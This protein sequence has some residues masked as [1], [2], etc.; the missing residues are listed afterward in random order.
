MGARGAGRH[1]DRLPG[2]DLVSTRSGLASVNHGWSMKGRR[3]GSN[4][5]MQE[6][7][8]RN[9]SPSAARG[10]DAV[11]GST[12]YGS[13]RRTCGSPVGETGGPVEAAYH[14]SHVTGIPAGLESLLAGQRPP[15]AVSA[16]GYAGY[17]AVGCAGRM[18]TPPRHRAPGTGASGLVDAEVSGPRGRRLGRGGRRDADPHRPSGSSTGPVDARDRVRAV[19]DGRLTLERIKDVMARRSRGRTP[20]PSGA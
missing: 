5:M 9:G 14:L 17:L 19:G 11:T 15:S 20:P 13:V 2:P 10:V 6:V 16:I 12:A 18:Q 8:G 7:V 4:L 3:R 1:V